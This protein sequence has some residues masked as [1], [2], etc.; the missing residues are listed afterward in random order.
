MHMID[1]NQPW[2]V[3]YDGEC[4]FC[5]RQIARIRRRDS[6]GR[7]EYV[8]RQTAGLTERFPALAE[9]D[10]DT[11]MRLIRPDGRV[12]VGADSVYKISRR[13]PAWLWFA[14]LYRIPGIHALARS[15]YAW[16]AAHR[17][18]LS[19]NRD[20][21]TRAVPVTPDSSVDQK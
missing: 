3:V 4:P 19:G 16:V 2:A 18:S 6:L 8:P 21:G 12:Y 13:L 14:W 17:Q 9:G 11:G 1:V 10:F 7:F 20:D 15:A 5:Q